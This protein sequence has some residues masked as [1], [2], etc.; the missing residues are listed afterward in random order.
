MILLH[1]D[2]LLLRQAF[3]FIYHHL[4][5]AESCWYF[6]WIHCVLQS[7]TFATI[8]ILFCYLL[9]LFK[10]FLFILIWLNTFFCLFL[11]HLC[12][13]RLFIYHRDAAI[14]LRSK[15]FILCKLFHFILPNSSFINPVT[16]PF[17][18]VGSGLSTS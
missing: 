6:L 8:L 9:T 17:L 14:Q 18:L 3:E 7:W 11:F 13:H 12:I 5:L 15:G 10:V 16:F 1:K 4:H 2:M